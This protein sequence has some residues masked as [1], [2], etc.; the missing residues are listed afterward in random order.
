[1]V[2]CYLAHADQLCFGERVRARNVL[3][4]EDETVLG[5][6]LDPTVR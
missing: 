6:T 3:L 1:V 2:N 5:C 4:N